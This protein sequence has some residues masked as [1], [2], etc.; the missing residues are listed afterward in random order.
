MIS[1]LRFEDIGQERTS[2]LLED[3]YSARRQWVLNFVPKFTDFIDKFPPFKG[4]GSH[5]SCF[6]F[7]ADNYKLV[8]SEDT[9]SSQ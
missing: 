1:E 3:T 2:S 7:Y 9:K 6:S 4:F 8:I 5:V